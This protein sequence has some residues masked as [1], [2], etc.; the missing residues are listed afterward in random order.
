M[1][2]IILIKMIKNVVNVLKN[3]C[4]QGKFVTKFENQ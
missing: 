2:L 1:G 3:L 4:Y